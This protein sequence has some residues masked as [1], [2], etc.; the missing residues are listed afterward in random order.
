MV[1]KVGQPLVGIDSQTGCVLHN[2]PPSK[3]LSV[4]YLLCKIKTPIG[5]VIA[6]LTRNKVL[7]PA[8]KKIRFF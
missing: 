3:K 6:K 7:F 4:T 5:P 8:K 1:E 2:P